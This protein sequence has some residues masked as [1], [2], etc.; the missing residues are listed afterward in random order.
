MMH[1]RGKSDSAVV[2]RK[3][4][5]R[6]SDWLRNRWSEGQGPREMW[7]AILTEAALAFPSSYVR[8]V[9]EGSRAP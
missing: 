9:N 4:V 8:Q 5:N 7:P 1:G 2:A 6:P 3:S